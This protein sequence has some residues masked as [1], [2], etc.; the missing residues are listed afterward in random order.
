[1]G[2]ERDEPYVVLEH[3]HQLQMSGATNWTHCLLGTL[4]VSAYA[5]AAAAAVAGGFRRRQPPRIECARALMTGRL[6]RYSILCFPSER[7][8]RAFHTA[9]LLRCTGTNEKL[10]LG[11]VDSKV[12]RFH[13]RWWR[14]PHWFRHSSCADQ[15]TRLF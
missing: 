10:F 2:T 8:S 1:M 5:A 6:P 14:L 3:E 4:S 7:S 12:S 9:Q 13:S 11:A 15:P